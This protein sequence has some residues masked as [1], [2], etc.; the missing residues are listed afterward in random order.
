MPAPVVSTMP[1]RLL[2]VPPFPPVASRLLRL[3]ADDSVKISEV[4]A[5][6]AS[7]ATFSARV[8]QYVN[9][10]E[11]GL[12]STVTNLNQALMMLGLDRTRRITLTLASAAYSGN[13]I[14]ATEVRR[15]WQHT[16]ATAV[17]AD[18]I[19]RLCNEFTQIAYTAGLMHDIGRLGLLVAYP[20][21]YE[22][23]IRDAASRSI[24]ILDFER[25]VFGVDHA[26]AGRWLA[27]RWLLPEEFRVVAGR[28][29]DSCDASETSLLTIIHVAC[30]LA[31]AL[32]YDVTRP[33]VAA[34]IE[35]IV[36]GLPDGAAGRILLEANDLR[37]QVEQAVH[38]FDSVTVLEDC[39]PP[40]AEPAGAD[41][42]FEI[43]LPPEASGAQTSSGLWAA[44]CVWVRRLL[45]FRDPGA[46]AAGSIPCKDGDEP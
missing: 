45:D 38:R 8:L 26:E 13:A 29:H 18:Y 21:E 44:L 14:K 37:K 46:E 1:Q 6:I 30:K 33:L 42:G 9:S 32:G 15:S 12:A 31:D 11:F 4:G 27:E 3:L 43:G 17:I 2:R 35:V 7:D 39:E 23:V 41:D 22:K 5:V 10:V 36:A 16:V 20:S 24:D 40:T 28:H 34:P 19:A 25:E